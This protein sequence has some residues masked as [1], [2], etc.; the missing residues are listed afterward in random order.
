MAQ[1]KKFSVI[2]P[3][4][5]DNWTT[6]GEMLFYLKEQDYK[7]F[8]VIISYNS[9]ALAASKAGVRKIL[10]AHPWVDFKE[11]DAGYDK[12]LGSGNH[13]AAFNK[14][15]E[16][17]TGDYLLFLDPDIR[18]L[19]GILREYKDAFD[20]HPEASFVYGDYDF[21]GG[22]GRI[23]GRPF[24]AYELKCANYISGAFPIRKEAF[25]GWDPTVKSLQDWDMWLSAL[26]AGAAGF[27][28][29]RPC[30]LADPPEAGGVSYDS[31][32]NWEK[33]YGYVRHKH[34][35]PVSDTVVTSLGAPDHATNAAEI[36]G[37]DS[38]VRNNLHVYKPNSYRNVYL[39]GFYSQGPAEDPTMAVRQHVGLFFEGGDLKKP[40]V[41]GKKVI[42]WVGTDI[43]MLQHKTSWAGAKFVANMLTD[44]ELGFVNLSEAKHTHD[45]LLELGIP[46]EIVPLPPKLLFDP[47]P[48]PKDF[49]VGVYTNPTQDMYHEELMYEIADAM[50]DVKFRFF[51]TRGAKRKEGNKEWVGW[52][53]MAEFL[54]TISA[55][56]RLTVH[57]GLPLGP[58]EAMTAGRNVLCST[59]LK[60]ALA[61]KHEGG[62]PDKAA[63]I[64]QIRELEKMGPNLEGSAYWKKELDHALYRKRIGEILGK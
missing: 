59:P 32:E 1:D 34:G 41:K 28:L 56:V 50:P 8:E 44:P 21:H 47:M 38:R 55:V 4:H 19:P 62:D 13:C 10:K 60:H 36:L 35:F 52:V 51:G 40:T 53:D 16:L 31:S 33:R 37:F 9:P 2:T 64:E 57:D 14:G 24:S 3:I 5:R 12:A 15:A 30:F 61:A 58:L 25:R 11:V 7:N 23:Q 39:I 26:D 43:H 22:H 63:V 54:P 42:H 17:A 46:S 49:T 18:I 27:Y 29:Q 45:E 6:L 20:Q 48:L